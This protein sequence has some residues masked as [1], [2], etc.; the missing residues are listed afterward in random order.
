MST[1]LVA[2]ATPRPLPVGPGLLLPGDKPIKVERT[3][4][5]EAY[6]AEGK[7]HEHEPPAKTARASNA[8]TKEA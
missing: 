2:N 8:D 5:I 7:L 4:L 6:L 1:V 3:P